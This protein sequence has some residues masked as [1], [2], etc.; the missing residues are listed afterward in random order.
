MI[1]SLSC[2]IAEEFQ[3]KEVASMDLEALADITA[4]A[5]Y[6]ALCM[7]ASQIGVHSSP[8]HVDAGRRIVFERSLG[9]SMVTGDFDTVYNNDKG[10]DALRKITP[11]LDLAEKLKAPLIRVAL[12]KE[13]D[14]PWAQKAADEAVDRG[15]SLVHQCHT[16]SL[17]ET[18]I[19]IEDTLKRI[20][21]E[22]FG[23]IFEPANLE[24]CGEAYGMETFKRLHTWIFN[25]YLQNQRLREDGE[26]TLQ[27]W[28]RGLVSLDLLPVH[29]AGGID[30]ERVFEG[31]NAVGYDQTITI[32]QSGT[33]GEREAD[34]VSKTADYVRSRFLS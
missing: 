6:D 10:P 28:C 27:T 3:S 14:I 33:P 22:N 29:E 32:H 20:G 7:R 18:V 25:V 9:V 16:L 5:G 1:L 19:G 13:D 21:R 34:T 30:F 15:I 31:L 23:L 17:F 2:R 4:A 26:F 12:K 11:Y 24:I 8:E